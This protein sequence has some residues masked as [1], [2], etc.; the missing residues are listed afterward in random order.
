MRL[1]G[2]VI[3]GLM[4]AAPARAQP[5]HNYDAIEQRRLD[6]ITEQQADNHRLAV[7]RPPDKPATETEKDA[8]KWRADH[9]T[10]A[11]PKGR[12]RAQYA[13]ECRPANPG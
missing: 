13:A 4:A 7:A 12:T 8:A 9:L 10:C 1:A 3:L 5:R 2:L 6:Q 11:S